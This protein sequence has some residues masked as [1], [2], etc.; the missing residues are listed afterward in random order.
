[1][2]RTPLFAAALSA[3]L[4]A[5]ATPAVAGYGALAHDSASG[6]FGLSWDKPTQKDADA[7]AMKD[8]VESACKIIF[9]THPHQCGAVATS[10][11]E[12]ST[13]WGGGVKGTREAAQLGAMQD[14][15]KHTSGQCKV[16]ASGCNR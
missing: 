8:C 1:M 11:K 4:L 2:R 15:Q 16:R 3:L 10:E 7:A 9:R 6:K 13:A 5:V 12:G 14:C